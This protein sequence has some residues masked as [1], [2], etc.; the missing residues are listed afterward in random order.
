MKWLCYKAQKSLEGIETWW[1][2][3][4]PPRVYHVTKHRNPWKGLKQKRLPNNKTTSFFVTKH[5]NP[6]KGLKPVQALLGLGFGSS[7]KAQKSLEGIETALEPTWN[8]IGKCRY[9]AQKSLEGIE[10]ITQVCAYFFF[11]VTKHRNPWKGLKRH[12]ERSWITIF[13]EVTKH[14]NPWKGLKPHLSP[15]MGGWW[16]RYKA[17]KSLEG[18]ETMSGTSAFI[19]CTIVTKHRNPWKGLKLARSMT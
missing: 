1:V 10:T 11:S 9:K 13:A 16:D 12:S 6:W 15:S 18:I 17:Q 8:L 14:R 4:C 2:F 5:R 7:Y 19:I 3:V